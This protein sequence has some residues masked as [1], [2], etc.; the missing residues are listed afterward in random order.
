MANTFTLTE[1]PPTF[2]F[3]GGGSLTISEASPVLSLIGRS[4]TAFTL[5]EPAPVL[6]MQGVSGRLDMTEPIPVFAATGS[7]SRGSF[8]FTEPIPVFAATGRKQTSF[9]L[10]EPIP[11]VD[12]LSKVESLFTFEEPVPTFSATGDIVATVTFTFSEPVPVLEFVG[13]LDLVDADSEY[14]N[15]TAWVVNPVNQVHS[16]FK[17]YE[18][19]SLFAFNGSYYG[20][21]S[22]G[23]FELVGNS[24]DGTEISSVN[25]WGDSEM[26]HPYHKRFYRANIE[27]RN[28]GDGTLTLGITTNETSRTTFSVDPTDVSGLHRKVIRGRRD[29]HGTEFSLDLYNV[30]GG[31]F[32]VHEIEVINQELKRGRG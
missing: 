3:I 29:V 6:V 15:Y 21:R 11:V 1:A 24:D 25:V 30:D 17:N 19:N 14:S 32:D 16:G 8:T 13:V 10:T 7:S 9:T 22:D 28:Q 4:P 18:F 5:Q 26:G 2:T 27:I 23:V 12:L 20:C 31:D